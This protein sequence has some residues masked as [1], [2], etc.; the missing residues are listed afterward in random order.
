[1]DAI[2]V[3]ELNEYNPGYKDRHLIWCKVYF[4]MINADPDFEL[5]CEIDKWRFV[6]LV[7][8]EL[9]LKEPVPLNEEYLKRK[10]FDFKKRPMS[11]SLHM[12]HNLVDVVTERN[13]TVTQSRLE[14][15]RL[16]EKRK[17]DRDVIFLDFEDAQ[18]LYPG[19]K[20]GVETELTDFR[21]KHADWKDVC[22]ALELA[23]RMQITKR[24]EMA[25]RKEFVPP[26]KNFKTYLYQRCWES[27]IG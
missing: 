15:S 25:N 2:H 12:L 27:Q 14:E 18:K 8:L 21:K 4:K 17:E 3:K 1:M 24:E 9:Q 19:T 5:L 26:W 16:E 7:M 13:A 10:G 22:P 20:R 11:L 23:I 6:A